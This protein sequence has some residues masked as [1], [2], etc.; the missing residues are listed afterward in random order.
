MRRATTVLAAL[1]AA[2]GAIGAPALAHGADPGPRPRRDGLTALRPDVG[3]AR[4]E[5]LAFRPGDVRHSQADIAKITTLLHYQPTHSVRLGL[6][7][8]LRWYAEQVEAEAARSA[9]P[10]GETPWDPAEPFPV[11]AT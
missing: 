11:R 3:S 7:V 2:I 9:E 8:A 4:P 10:E 5:F 1:A 6:D